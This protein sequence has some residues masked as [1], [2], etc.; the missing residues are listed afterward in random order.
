MKQN[1]HY[2]YT[3]FVIII[4]LQKNNQYFLEQLWIFEIIVYDERELLE[5]IYS[6]GATCTYSC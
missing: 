6:Y 5:V 4:D 3:V 1:H 2:V